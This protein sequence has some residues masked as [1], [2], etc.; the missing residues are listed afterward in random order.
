M[1]RF[2]VRS[3]PLALI[4]LSF[5]AG[6]F[7]QVQ[8]GMP[9]FG[10]FGGGPDVIDLA[11]LNA[12]LSMPIVNKA[13]RGLPFSYV[14]SYDSSVWFATAVNGVQTW[15]PVLGWGW[16]GSTEAAT[17]YISYTKT[18]E[19][20]RN[21]GG[22]LVPGIDLMSNW[23]YHDST[24]IPHKFS[25]STKV[26]TACTTLVMSFTNTT[27]D[28]SGFTLNANGYSGT[29]TVQDGSIVTPPIV[30][31]TGA[32]DFIDRNGNEITAT[33]ANV[34]TD[35]LGQTALTISGTNPKTLSYTGPSGTQS[36]TVKY[37]TYTVQTNFGCSGISEF[38]ASSTPLVSEIDLPD[39]TKYSF[40]Y[41]AT[42]QHTP[43][44]TGRLAS[45][46]LPTGGVISYS[47]GSSGV[48]G[49]TCADGSASSLARITPDGIWRY[50]RSGAA[51]AWTTTITDP[52]NNQTVLAFQGLY[53]TQ[54]QVYQGSTTGTLLETVSTCYNGNTT[55]CS[56]TA[57]NLPI[58]QRTSV[59]QLPGGLQSRTDL[60]YNGYGLVTEKDEY[61]FGTNSPGAILRKTLTT[62]ASLGNG[63]V[64]MPATVIV[65]DGASTIKGQATY[66]YDQ[67]SPTP[68]SG[69]PQL[70]P[71]TGSRGNLTTATFVTQ[72]AASLSKTYTY[73]DTGTFNVVTDV[74]GAQTTY[75]YG[76]GSC[77]N[78]FPTLINEPLGMSRSMTWNCNGSVK[79]STIDENNNSTSTTYTDN[80]FWR[81]HSITDAAS[82]VTTFAYTGATQVESSMAVGSGVV[83]ML[84][85]I[86]SLGRSHLSQRKQGPSSMTYDSIETDY[87]SA[88]RSSRTTLPYSGSA[89]A[90]NPTG[91]ATIATYDS[92]GRKTQETDASGL[93]LTITYTQNDI[94][95][96]LGPFP[97]GENT[98]R[99]QMEYDALG[100]LTSVCEI[101]TATGSGTCGQTIAVTG[102]WT[103]YSY[104]VLNN[105]TGVTQNAQSA[106]SQIRSYSYDSLSRMT[107]ETS[108]ESGTTTYTYDS[109]GTCG[110]YPGDLVKKVDA[111]GNVT[112]FTYDPFHRVTIATVVS[113]PYSGNTPIKH[114]VYD[115][116][117]VNGAT[118]NNAK[119]RMAEAYTC[120]SPC[121]SKITDLGISYTVL[122]QVSDAYEST[123]HSSGFYR[124]TESF[125]SNGAIHQLSNVAG[126]PTMT[127]GVDSEGRISSASASSGQN[128]LLSTTYNVASLPTQVN[129]GS[130]DSDTYT[131]D[132]NSYRMTQYKFNVNG[133]SVIG[134]LTWNP[135][136]TLASLVITDPFNGANAQ[137]C[138]Y[139][140]DDLSRIA[141][142]NCGTPWAQTFSYDPFGNLSKSGTSSFQPTYSYLTNHMT[143]IGSSTPTYDSNGNVTNDFLHTY[144]WD[145]NGRPVTV[146]NVGI[147]YDALGRMVE[148]N[149]NGSYTEVLYGPQG[150]KLALM[151]GQTLQKAFIPLAGGAM[152]VYNTSGLSFYRHSDW[153]GSSRLAST[154]ARGI[155][156]ESAYGP[157]G[158]TYAQSGTADV[159]FTGMNQDT[160][161]NLYDFPAREYGIQGRWPS[162]DPAGLSAASLSN[163]QTLNRYA[164]ASNSPLNLTD[165]TGLCS[166]CRGVPI[167]PDSFVCS[168]TL[169]CNGDRIISSDYGTPIFGN[170]VFDALEGQ[171]GT[172]L[173]IDSRGGLQFG[174]S[175]QLWKSTWSWIDSTRKIKTYGWTLPPWTGV[176]EPVT[177]P[178]PGKVQMTGYIVTAD[179]MGNISGFIPDIG[180]AQ[181]AYASYYHPIFDQYLAFMQMI[182]ALQHNPDID[183]PID[184]QAEWQRQLQA[185]NRVAEWS[186]AAPDLPLFYRAE[187]H[188]I[189]VA[190]VYLPD[191]MS[192]R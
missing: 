64:N 93:N 109:D 18:K 159:S 1:N 60:F 40:S 135:I 12:H 72:G 10:S 63:I 100:R 137:S 103:R 2:L 190:L 188:F 59:V 74:N 150:S 66:A 68:T 3:L 170:D 4:F 121:T 17:G 113:G 52:Q 156:S 139:K 182:D 145:A 115:S 132:P 118:M 173:Y 29:I 43:N 140:H 55:N 58:T 51:P 165:P 104:D 82:N 180:A 8:T 191:L 151:T 119:G 106:S 130:S 25:G 85:T 98:K 154:P 23:V 160:A 37:T 53:E 7:G 62:Y 144:V 77:G 42:Y 65:E 22:A 13:G 47:Y 83:D 33:N 69:T 124:A 54:R 157:F 45:V 78:S 189:D 99:K 88:G 38:S 172:F 32:G 49:I 95:E 181:A 5:V 162:P 163:P 9:P 187:L 92:L 192:P 122:G 30:T 94:Y 112:C 155:Y 20:C 24:G 86:D 117:T 174:F 57:V 146:D 114:F 44:V 15:Q 179:W 141:S 123:P 71:I 134:N 76:T 50:S 164:Y 175:I 108:P 183:S 80:F 149:R 96:S 75:S 87:D 177:L 28:G 131:F 79:L 31:P 171:P 61:A 26:Y 133:Q 11:N 161:S 147:T 73:Y 143:Q 41:E 185:W 97:T 167:P 169:E 90:N 129:L 101:T 168:E 19:K 48:N 158:E 120:V 36:F 142:A 21:A 184:P 152:A 186:D 166:G 116:A 138:S 91:P 110:T 46:T 16:R 128:P 178:V 102:Y 14:Y 176:K 81:P 35:T 67:T 56:S 111:A 105:P 34:F 107:A 148:Q 39:G 136:G 127:Y 89:G 126:L 125:W 153:L 70:V 27:N 84:S 6:T